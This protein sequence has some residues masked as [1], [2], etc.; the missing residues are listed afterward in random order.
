MG[1]QN[2]QFAQFSVTPGTGTAAPG[3]NLGFESGDCS[4]R[5]CYGGAVAVA[6]NAHAGGYSVQLLPN[7][8][9]EKT[10]S[11]PTPNTTSACRPA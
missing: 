7:S 5:S 8:G 11:G 10:V 1:Y 3:T 2:D 4:G 6:A 9:A